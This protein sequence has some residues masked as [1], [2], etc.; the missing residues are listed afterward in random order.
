MSKKELST[1]NRGG[2]KKVKF[3]IYCRT[4]NTQC[5]TSVTLNVDKSKSS[6][7]VDLTMTPFMSMTLSMT[8]INVVN[9]PILK[10]GSKIKIFANIYLGIAPKL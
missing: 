7:F 6:C 1:K 5:A 4:F 9:V 2:H 10:L 3:V 8:F